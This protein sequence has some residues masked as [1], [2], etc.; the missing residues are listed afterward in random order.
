MYISIDMGGTYTRIASSKDLKSIYRHIKFNT[1]KSLADQKNLINYNIK[2]LS[3]NKQI[4]A[5]CLG[6]PGTL[7]RKNEIYLKFP[8]YKVLEGKP[9]TE[10]LGR[11]FSKMP[12]IVIN[13]AHMAGYMEAVKGAGKPFKSVLYIS[14]GT[15]IGG[16]WI[17]N[18][19]IDDIFPNFE[20]GHEAIFADGLDF[21]DHCSGHGFRRVHGIPSSKHVSPDIWKLYARDL[22]KGIAFL[23]KKYPSDAVVLGGG[24][25]VN[26]FKYFSKYLPKEPHI[27]LADYKDN[28]GLLGGLEILS[29][30]LS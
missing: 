11:E 19:S 28:S 7:D 12:L 25:S 3:D 5:I 29:K 10:L 26:N 1:K 14:I 22:E 18:K 17:R 24:V 16:I 20:P 15:G 27:L 9:F 6:V 4:L 23:L 2:K 13:D 30:S 21:E 8:N